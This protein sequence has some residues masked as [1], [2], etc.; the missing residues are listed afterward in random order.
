MLAS[1]L[2]SIINPNNFLAHYFIDISPSSYIF[3]L[4]HF[5]YE[6]TST[7][8]PSEIIESRKCCDGGRLGVADDDS[9]C[10]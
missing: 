2:D 7:R 5:T 3:K 4:K 10:K 1:Y 8:R 9:G 6:L